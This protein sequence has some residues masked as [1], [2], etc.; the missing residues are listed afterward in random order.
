VNGTVAQDGPTAIT[1]TVRIRVPGW[2]FG[3]VVLL[4][5]L[6]IFIFVRISKSY[7]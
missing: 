3:L 5:V 7:S 2:D 1:T 4:F 6:A